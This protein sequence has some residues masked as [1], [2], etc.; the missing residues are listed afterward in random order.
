MLSASGSGWRR[1]RA[2]F[3]RPSSTAPCL[4]LVL[5]AVSANIVPVR[6]NTCFWLEDGRFYGW[7]GCFDNAGCCAG[8]CTHV[9]SYAY[10]VAYLFPSL[11]REMRRI[12]FE[13]ETEPDGFM[14]FRNFKSM[15]E[16]FIWTWG[17]QQAGSRLRRAVG[18]HPA[19]LPRMAA[20]RRPRLAAKPVGGHQAGD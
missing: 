18:Q 10:T 15:G 9:W 8:S 3:T 4:A 2:A 12:E 20:L 19:R 1:T 11:E 17:D 7:E 6:S 5:D 16:E 13:V 14:N